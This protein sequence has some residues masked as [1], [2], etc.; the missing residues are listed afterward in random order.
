[1]TEQELYEAYQQALEAESLAHRDTPE[2]I[3]VR[4]AFFAWVKSTPQSTQQEKD[5]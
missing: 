5:S 4:E 3:A 1:V 2:T